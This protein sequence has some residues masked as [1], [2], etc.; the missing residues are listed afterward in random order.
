MNIGRIITIF[1]IIQILA[2]IVYSIASYQ[3]EKAASDPY[4]VTKFSEK[5]NIFALVLTWQVSAFLIFFFKGWPILAI[6][7]PLLLTLFFIWVAYTIDKK[8]FSKK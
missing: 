7:I 1:I 4:E 8:M 2:G 3:A 5:Y 6:I